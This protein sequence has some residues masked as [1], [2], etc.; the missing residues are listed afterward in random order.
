LTDI[1]LLYLAVKLLLGVPPPTMV[2]ILLLS[3]KGTKSLDRCHPI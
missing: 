3:N 1:V 2:H